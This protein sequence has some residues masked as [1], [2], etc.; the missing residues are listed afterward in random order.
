L[1][2][3]QRRADENITRAYFRSKG[4]GT[5]YETGDNIFTSAYVDTP[6]ERLQ[7]TGVQGRAKD[8]SSAATISVVSARDIVA[9]V[10][11]EVDMSNV[12]TMTV[13]TGEKCPILS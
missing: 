4:T 10:T 12:H 13:S 2:Y 6:G 1:L 8:V 3:I 7:L 5:A 9:S 11:E